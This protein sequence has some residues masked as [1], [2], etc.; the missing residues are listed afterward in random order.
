M[1]NSDVQQPATEEAGGR[2][3]EGRMPRSLVGG[4]DVPDEVECDVLVAGSGAA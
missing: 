1:S 2:I 4:A 3:A